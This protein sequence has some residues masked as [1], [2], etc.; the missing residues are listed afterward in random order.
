MPAV[1]R[2]GFIGAGSVA[3]RHATTLGGFDD[4]DVVAVTDPAEEASAALAGIAGGARRHADP[5]AMLAAG[6]LDAVYVCVPPFAHGD[7]ERLVLGAGLP[8]FVEK[9]LSVDLGTAEAIAAEVR[10]AGVPTATGYHWR[11]LQVAER[12]RQALAERPARLAQ[13]AWLD[14]VPPPGWWIRRDRSGGQIV[15]QTTHLLDL[16]LDLLGDVE[17]VYALATKTPRAAFPDADVDDV[18]SATLRFASGAV[19]SVTSTCLLAAKHRAGIELFG[20][21]LALTLTETELVV[22]T[23]EGP[24]RMTD[25]GDAKIRVDRDFIDAVQGKEDRIRVPYATALETHRLATAITRSAQS[26]APVRPADG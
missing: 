15:E 25:P 19:G 24:R 7:P 11:G 14:K 1:I 22:D 13:A 16:L 6:G 2:V 26:G 23:G 10:A 18:T 12:A 5:E 3:Q 21:G 8:L 17:E 20:E 4:V 9:P